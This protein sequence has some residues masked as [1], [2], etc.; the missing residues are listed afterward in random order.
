MF[1]LSMS[2]LILTCDILFHYLMFVVFT[3]YLDVVPYAFWLRVW[4]RLQAQGSTCTR[5]LHL[6]CLLTHYDY[7]KKFQWYTDN[8]KGGL[9]CTERPDQVLCE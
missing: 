4:W 9:N 7:K 5:S 8:E 6:C 1:D 2:F 3:Q